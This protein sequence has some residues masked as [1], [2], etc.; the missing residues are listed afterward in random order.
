MTG[1]SSTEWHEKRDKSKEHKGT[2]RE[3]LVLSALW[4]HTLGRWNDPKD[5]STQGVT[6]NKMTEEG[7]LTGSVPR[8]MSLSGRC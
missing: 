4:Q 6:D 8:E 2:F 1:I 3:L 7:V 5:H